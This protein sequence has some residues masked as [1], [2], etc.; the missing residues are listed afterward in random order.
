[1]VVPPLLP[2]AILAPALDAAYIRQRTGVIPAG[3]N[4]HHATRQPT[5]IYRVVWN[6]SCHRP[7]DRL[8][9]RPSI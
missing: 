4:R 5:D 8:R 9:C 1:M 6:P 7:T 3:R 2:V